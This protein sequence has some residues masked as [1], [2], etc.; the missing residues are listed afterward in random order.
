M[1]IAL[2]EFFQHSAWASEQLIAGCEQL[3]EE[4]LEATGDGTYGSTRSTLAHM[5]SAEQ[6]YL[7]RIGSPQPADVLVTG[8]SDFEVLGRAARASGLA[9]AQAADSLS[10][11]DL[12]VGCADD[13]FSQ[14]SVS[15]FLIQ[16]LSHSAEHR[17]QVL[18]ILGALGAGPPN[19]DAQID[20][21]SWGGESGTLVN[22]PR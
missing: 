5:L 12:V 16:A 13:E 14:A 6:Y 4:Q 19:F 20:G 7:Q 22:K 1:A 3:N 21:W 18:G 10:S 2:S 17:T 8:S 15:V 9:L 11:S